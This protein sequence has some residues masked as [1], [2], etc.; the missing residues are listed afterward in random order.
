MSYWL[1]AAR[2]ACE[3]G[4]AARVRAPG[5]KWAPPASLMMG[6]GAPSQSGARRVAGG[7]W[8]R[9]WARVVA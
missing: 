2:I 9:C 1:G 6:Q 5:K 7:E 4:R 3:K 8:W